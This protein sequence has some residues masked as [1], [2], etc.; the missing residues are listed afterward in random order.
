VR[1]RRK[2]EDEPEG[3]EDAAQQSADEPG[4]G[5]S[6]WALPADAAV[7]S[8]GD[9][10]RPPDSEAQWRSGDPEVDPEP[11]EPPQPAAAEPISA[12]RVSSPGAGLFDGPRAAAAAGA[13]SFAQPAAAEPSTGAADAGTSTSSGSAADRPELF[14]AGAFVGAFLF[15]K[16]IKRI[17]D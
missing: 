15:A 8:G 11:V 1:F 3:V 7:A 4:P 12:A 16:I 5:D 13:G 17:G 9:V 6:A 2:K 10:A 14:V